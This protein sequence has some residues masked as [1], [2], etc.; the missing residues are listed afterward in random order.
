[1][2]I[3]IHQPLSVYAPPVSLFF[4]LLSGSHGAAHRCS[5]SKTQRSLPLHIDLIRPCTLRL[6]LPGHATKSVVPCSAPFI[7]IA[8][9]PLLVA[10]NFVLPSPYERHC[11]PR[12][13]PTTWAI[14]TNTNTAS[15]APHESM[16]FLRGTRSCFS[17]GMSSPYI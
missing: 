3:F 13:R 14:A 7:C 10:A 5:K 2:T 17:L 16:S 9:Y 15:H 11:W 12:P 8:M 1:M 6:A 4:Y